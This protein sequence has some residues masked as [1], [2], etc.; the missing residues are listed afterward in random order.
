MFAQTEGT[1]AGGSKRPLSGTRNLEGRVASMVDID[2]IDALL[3][4]F[5]T[6]SEQPIGMWYQIDPSIVPR[7]TLRDRN[8]RSNDVCLRNWRAAT[9]APS[10]G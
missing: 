4:P 2:R 7:R 6:P 9:F 1:V 5:S 10:M 3:H 8:S